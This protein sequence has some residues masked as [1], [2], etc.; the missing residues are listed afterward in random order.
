VVPRLQPV[1]APAPVLSRRTLEVVRRRPPSGS[2]QRALQEGAVVLECRVGERP[3]ELAMQ[4]ST[5]TGFLAWLESRPPGATLPVW[6]PR[7]PA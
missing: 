4:P 2:E 6:T 5:V 7:R 1:P 3:V